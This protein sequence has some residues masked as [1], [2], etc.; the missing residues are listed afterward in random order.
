MPFESI[1]ILPIYHNNWFRAG[2]VG[3]M[4]PYSTKSADNWSKRIPSRFRLIKMGNGGEEEDDDEKKKKKKNIGQEFLILSL[5]Y[6]RPFRPESIFSNFRNQSDGSF[7]LQSFRL[8][9]RSGEMERRKGEREKRKKRQKKTNKSSS[10]SN[11][12][13]NHNNKIK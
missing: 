12:N 2:I 7:S 6:F 13:N 8:G 3:E 11:N 4:S 10:S 9:R 5:I 1:Q